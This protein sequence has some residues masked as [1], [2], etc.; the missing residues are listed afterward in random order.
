MSLEPLKR[1]LNKELSDVE[2]CL[3]KVLKQE[4]QLSI[5]EINDYLIATPGKRIRPTLV[6]LAFKA[7]YG[8]KKV[9]PC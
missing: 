1:L 4:T 7:I 5:Q 9:D 8:T 3:K 2:S 6:I